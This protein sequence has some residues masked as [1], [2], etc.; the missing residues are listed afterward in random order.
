MNYGLM[1]FY[2]KF[3]PNDL[4]M[5][6]EWSVNDYDHDVLLKGFSHKYI[7][8]RCDKFPHIINDSKLEMFSHIIESKI[9]SYLNEIIL[10]L[11]SKNTCQWMM[12]YLGW[13]RL[14]ALLWLIRTSRRIDFFMGFMLSTKV[15]VR[16]LEVIC[17]S[18]TYM[19]R[20]ND[21]LDR[22]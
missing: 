9:R 11:L 3:N 8:S 21:W 22:H 7:K 5:L 17:L 13:A 15:E 6:W 10:E 14:Y 16:F 12:T 1:C 4:G 18:H 2:R 20:Y 19:P